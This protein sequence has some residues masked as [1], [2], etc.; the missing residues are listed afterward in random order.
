MP[1]RG[2]GFFLILGGVGSLDPPWGP[3]DPHLPGAAGKYFWDS[4]G[5]GRKVLVGEVVIQCSPPLKFT[6]EATGFIRP[7][8]N[9]T[10]P[11]IPNEKLLTHT[12][13]TCCAQVCSQFDLTYLNTHIYI[14]LYTSVYMYTSVYIYLSL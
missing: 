14:Y 4:L 7:A 5:N 6:G 2:T 9:N 8:G 11:L 1:G 12:L 3:E 10:Q 13:T